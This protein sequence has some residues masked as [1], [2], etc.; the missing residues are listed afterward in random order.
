MRKNEFYDWTKFAERLRKNR[1]ISGLTLEQLAE[2][3]DR[4][5][6]YVARL[7]KGQRGCSIY[8]LC[9][10]S[11][12]LDVSVDELLLGKKKNENQ[13]SEKKQ[14]L[15]DIIDKCDSQQLDLISDV[16]LTLYHKLKD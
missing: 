8:T 10:L 6:N 12:V 7:E 4:S 14:Q 15:L 5:D 13:N 1:A 2:K 9:Q 16:I 11:E 3:I